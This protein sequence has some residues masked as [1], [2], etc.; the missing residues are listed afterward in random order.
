[1]LE[2]VMSFIMFI[3]M[4]FFASFL[5]CLTDEII[6]I[7]WVFAFYFLTNGLIKHNDFWLLLSALFA[8]AGSVGGIGKKWRANARKKE[9]EKENGT[10]NGNRSGMDA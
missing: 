6:T 3:C 9:K 1:M 10:L 8:I 4:I 7:G 5:M 2:T